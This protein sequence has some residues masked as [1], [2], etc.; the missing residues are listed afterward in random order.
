MLQHVS[1]IAFFKALLPFYGIYYAVLL[2]YFYFEKIKAALRQKKSPLPIL[3]AAALLGTTVNSYAQTPDANAGLNQAN[4]MIR[5]YFETGVQILYAAGALIAL[6]GAGSI[7]AHWGRSQNDL[8]KEAAGWL[9]GCIFLVV[10]ATV[11]KSFFG[12]Q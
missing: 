6:I 4:S 11:I 12:I 2:Y 3:L 10:V 8:V 9:A 5:S 1:W 7:Y